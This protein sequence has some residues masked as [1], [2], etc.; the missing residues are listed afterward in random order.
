MCVCGPVLYF[1]SPLVRSLCLYVFYVW[2]RYFSLYACMCFSRSLIIPLV[3]S[4]LLYVFRYALIVP[5]CFCMYACLSFVRFLEVLRYVVLLAAALSLF[6][7]F[8][9]F[10]M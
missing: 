3:S 8:S 2:V 6:G 5:Y 9:W 4:S 1:F 7:E 10:A